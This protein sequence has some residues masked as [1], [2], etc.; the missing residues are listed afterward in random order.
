MNK[1]SPT[2]ASILS[3]LIIVFFASCAKKDNY[4]NT[5]STSKANTLRVMANVAN[6][7][8]K[9][10]YAA[11]PGSSRQTVWL[12]HLD[13]IEIQRGFTGSKL[14][15]LDSARHFLQQY[16]FG[17]SNDTSAEVFFDSW[18]TGAEYVL[19]TEEMY[20]IWFSLFDSISD[21]GKMYTDGGGGGTNPIK[22]NCNCKLDNFWACMASP[23]KCHSVDCSRG[24]GCGIL[25]LRTCNGRCSIF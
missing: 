2:H 8:L 11:L 13:S 21:E 20:L 3:L 9:A 14:L 7:D 16:D 5:P 22:D 24:L 18:K 4:Q 6:S 10:A 12:A 25:W 15:Y 23:D 17:A 19:S 1:V